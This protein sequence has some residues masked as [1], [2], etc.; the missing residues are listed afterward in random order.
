MASGHSA[1][2]SPHLLSLL[3]PLHSQ[4]SYRDQQLPLSGAGLLLTWF[5]W[6]L[7]PKTFYQSL[8]LTRCS[9]WLQFSSWRKV[10]PT[11][12]TWAW[13]PLQWHRKESVLHP[14]CSQPRIHRVPGGQRSIQHQGN[15]SP[16]SPPGSTHWSQ[17]PPSL[18]GL[19]RKPCAS[20][21]W[22]PFALHP[23]LADQPT[24]HHKLLP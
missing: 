18:G 19:Q 20:M 16:Q 9:V 5:P 12:P 1:P 15:G 21:S 7:T 6:I 24:R 4:H 14:P 10:V 11:H 8:V 13:S 2:S 23:L 22:G 3:S 17:G